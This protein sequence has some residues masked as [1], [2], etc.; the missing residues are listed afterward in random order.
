M[1]ERL[2]LAPSL[3]DAYLIHGA[4]CLD[5][6]NQM[7]NR[8]EPDEIHPAILL[9]LQNLNILIQLKDSQSDY[10]AVEVLMWARAELIKMPIDDEYRLLDTLDT[11]QPD[12]E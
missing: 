4:V 6:N 2:L 9:V 11:K 7:S 10:V 3:I 12:T 1:A 5:S 8:P